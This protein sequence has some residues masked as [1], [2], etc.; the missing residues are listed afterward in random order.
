MDKFIGFPL[1][2]P[3]FH[4]FSHLFPLVFQRFSIGKTIGF[5]AISIRHCPGD[6][7]LS[8]RSGH[9]GTGGTKGWHHHHGHGASIGFSDFAMGKA[10]EFMDGPNVPLI[11]LKFV[12]FLMFLPKHST[13][14]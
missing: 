14:D 8:G 12:V 7:S 2:F 13:E 4:G 6:G 5:P 3:K 9:C 11:S 1:V 10:D